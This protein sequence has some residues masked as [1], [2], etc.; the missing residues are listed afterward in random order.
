VEV[1][2]KKVIA[3]GVKGI[4]LRVHGVIRRQEDKER[5]TL[6]QRALDLEN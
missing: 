1:R 2:G 5:Q 4:I 6:D 3:E